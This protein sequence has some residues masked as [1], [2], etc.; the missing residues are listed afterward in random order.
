MND[1]PTIVDISPPPT[2]YAAAV[3]EFRDNLDLT[4][5]HYRLIS[6][7]KWAQYNALKEEGFTEAQALE[8][9]K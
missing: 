8:L 9:C 5:E 7:V 6:K 4:L 1:K 3:A 2:K